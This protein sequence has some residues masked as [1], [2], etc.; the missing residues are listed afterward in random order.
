MDIEKGVHIEPSDVNSQEWRLNI[1]VYSGNETAEE[2]AVEHRL[3][4]LNNNADDESL[5]YVFIGTESNVK[6]AFEEYLLRIDEKS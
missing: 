1:E 2:F 6:Q 5:S 3:I 4:A